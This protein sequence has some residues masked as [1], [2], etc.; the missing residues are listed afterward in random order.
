M[1]RRREQG[2]ITVFLS[3]ILLILICFV[4]ALVDG[5]RM[6]TAHSQV[7]RAIDNAVRA[8]L[9]DYDTKLKDA[10][11]FMAM[12][13]ENADLNSTAQTFLQKN[14][15]VDKSD[16]K[17][18]TDLYHY[19]I[20]SVKA[21]GLNPLSDDNVFK[22]QLLE[23]MK[24]RAPLNLVDGII[25]RFQKFKSLTKITDATNKKKAL[26]DEIEKVKDY[27]DKYVDAANSYKSIIG[28][29]K[30]S[31]SYNKINPP[32]NDSD[33]ESLALAVYLR[34]VIL[35]YTQ[36]DEYDKEKPEDKDKIDTFRTTLDSA[37][38]NEYYKMNSLLDMLVSKGSDL[39]N[40]INDYLNEMKKVKPL[41][42]DYAKAVEALKNDP[43]VSSYYDGYID[44]LGKYSKLF[45]G[46][47]N[48]KKQIDVIKANA[49]K[50]AG[51]K[52][53]L[54]D[55][56]SDRTE[57]YNFYKADDKSIDEIDKMAS[58]NNFD[59]TKKD[60][61]NYK[62]IMHQFDKQ[63]GWINDS[64][65]KIR[66][67]ASIND[68]DII[69][70]TD[71]KPSGKKDEG[72]KKDAQNK[73][74]DNSK[75]PEDNTKKGIPDSLWSKLPSKIAGYG[76][77]GVTVGS[78]Y[79]ADT[80]TVTAGNSIIDKI[81]AAVENALLG[82]RDKYY[83]D[84]YVMTEFRDKVGNK[85]NFRV[86]AQ[87][88]LPDG[89]SAP[90][91]YEIEYVINGAKTDKENADNIW[92]RTYIIRCALDFAYIVTD[93]TKKHEVT[94]IATAAVGW[95]GDG[96]FIKPMEAL[97]LACWSMLEASYDMK[98]IMDG[99]RIPVIKGSKTWFTDTF[100]VISP[101]R[102]EKVIKICDE[103]PL[104]LSYHDYLMFYLLL[105]SEDTT[106]A[107][108]KDLVYV[109]MDPNN[110]Y[111]LTK[112]FTTVCVEAQVSINYIFMTEAFMPAEGRKDKGSR[113]TIKMKRYKNY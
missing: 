57:A 13:T 48:L 108:I 38:L 27:Y 98:A 37:A 69:I 79:A 70:V 41:Y 20:E 54:G 94:A 26:D 39:T 40:K 105:Q 84:E 103:D 11:G 4:G 51:I 15:L 6:V 67:S 1:I 88:T 71:G 89:I 58:E 111:D 36:S 63:V 49:D 55:L 12:N 25:D 22:E 34:K 18:F 35:R 31:F 47:D 5:T 92:I 102:L 83:I 8:E 90:E 75:P 106:L 96:I 19:D 64:G 86:P 68:I 74:K 62:D 30:K 42:D 2:V 59:T 73:A 78:D 32:S 93:D 17:Q 3:L 99:H 24:Y 82:V 16:G 77:D 76:G 95:I 45:T 101:S 109:N 52:K 87:R 66:D 81:C 113:Y 60:A 33:L 107:R 97:L 14:L 10:Y 91:D 85:S 65:K 43:N 112:K 61:D 28:S 53:P 44:D 29:I 56:L 7:S 104:A 46:E 23:Y 80:S 50:I 21:S 72:G 100:N 9:A 110:G